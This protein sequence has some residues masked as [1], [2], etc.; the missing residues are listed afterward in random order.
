MVLKED[1]SGLVEAG[2][3]ERGWLARRGNVPLGYYKDPEKTERTFPVVD[4]TRPV[5]IIET[6]SIVAT[7]RPAL[8]WL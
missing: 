7:R 6:A 3:D 4:G 8:H 2:S 5:S 1:L